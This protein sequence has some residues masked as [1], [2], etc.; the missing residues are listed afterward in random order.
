MS[1]YLV[2]ETQSIEGAC[3]EGA[4][5]RGSKPSVANGSK[6]VATNQIIASDRGHAAECHLTR[7]DKLV[8]MTAH[9]GSQGQANKPKRPCPTVTC[10]PMMDLHARHLALGMS[11]SNHSPAFQPCWPRQPR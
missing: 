3:S 5:H 1:R 10:I 9:E 8:Y 2:V 4:E 7:Q 6:K 11:Q